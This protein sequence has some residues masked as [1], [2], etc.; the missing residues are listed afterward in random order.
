MRLRLSCLLFLLPAALSAQS[1]GDRLLHPSLSSATLVTERYSFEN[2]QFGKGALS[3]LSAGF[4]TS[5]SPF[6]LNGTY[7]IAGGRIITCEATWQPVA[8]IGVRVGM[9]KMPFLTETTFSPTNIGLVG[10][11][12]AASYLGGY[13]G[14]LTGI[15]SRS[16]D[17]G[18]LL[19]GSLWPQDGYSLLNY[20]VGVFQGNGY[21]FRDNNNAKDLQGRMIFQPSPYLK[22]SLGGMYGHYTPEGTSLLAARHRVST[23]VWYDNGT[24]FL[25][26]ENIYGIT[27]GT[28]SDGIMAMAGWW[29]QPRLLLAGR[30]DRFQKDLS[31]TESTV[32]RAD[33][34]FSHLLTP[35]GMICYRIQYRHTFYSDPLKQGT[36]L[37]MLCLC[38]SFR[39]RI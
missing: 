3:L 5:G 36:D 12:Q 37:L 31:D 22:V 20:S 18:I 24:W 35:D 29:F 17:V 38:F 21:S 23:G 8:Q 1:V 2:N 13:S 27:D 10:Y 34:G 15:N 16:R 28:R 30:L 9:Q 6:R 25:R 11:S 39:T 7:D 32:T 33:L 4:G 14:D 26:G 19:Q